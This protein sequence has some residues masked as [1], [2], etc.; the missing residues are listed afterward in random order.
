MN[1]GAPV[2]GFNR[3]SVAEAQTTAFSLT[4]TDP[5]GDVLTF[6]LS[7][8]DEALFSVSDSGIV[9]FNDAP[10]YEA[11]TDSDSDGVYAVSASVSDGSLSDTVSV[12]ISVVDAE[13][14]SGILI[15]G[16]LAGSTVF[17]T[18]TRIWWTLMSH[19]PPQMFWGTSV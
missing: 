15:D 6:T 2:V 14:A 9:T 5:H 12:L 16:Y 8:A 7:G 4:A 18:S 19:Q 11:P 3:V 10:D 17:R 13:A 1:A